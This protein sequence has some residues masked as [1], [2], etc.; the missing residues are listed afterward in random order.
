MAVFTKYGHEFF[1]DKTTAASHY[2]FHNLPFEFS[3]NVFW[4]KGSFS[5]GRRRW[6]ARGTPF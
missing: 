6:A 5:F 1:S 3:E 2:D 4:E